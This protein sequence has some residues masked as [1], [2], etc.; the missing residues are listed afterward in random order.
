MQGGVDAPSRNIPVPRKGADGETVKKLTLRKESKCCP[1]F[2]A[3]IWPIN[4]VCTSG[5]CFASPGILSK[6]FFHGFGAVAKMNARRRA[7]IDFREANRFL[8]NRPVCAFQRNGDICLMAHPPRLAKAG[9]LKA[10]LTATLMKRS[11]QVNRTCVENG[12]YRART[13]DLSGVNRM[14][15]QLS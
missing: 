10:V 12:R 6:S 13:Y 4:D 1:E 7:A 11:H 14:L 8:D 2:F 5:R 3:F 9:S 15:F